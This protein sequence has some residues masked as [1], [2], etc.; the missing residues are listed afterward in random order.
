MTIEDL[1]R[2]LANAEK[3]LEYEALP[4]YTAEYVMRLLEELITT[5]RLQELTTTRE[6]PEPH[7]PPAIAPAL[8]LSPYLCMR[9]FTG[10]RSDGGGC[11]AC[12]G[13]SYTIALE[14]RLKAI[15]LRLFRTGRLAQVEALL[16]FCER[17]LP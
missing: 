2:D 11:S 12:G 3:R 10:T 14:L 16:G 7:L 8:G 1:K 6:S 13:L 5:K 15:A 4:G 9:C 17:T